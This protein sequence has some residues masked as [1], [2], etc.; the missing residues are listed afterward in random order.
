MRR[1]AH[2]QREIRRSK[3]KEDINPTSRQT[4]VS[5]IDEGINA[6]IAGRKETTP[7]AAGRTTITTT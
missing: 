4:M 1:E 5:T 7:E 3:I 6:T 2:N